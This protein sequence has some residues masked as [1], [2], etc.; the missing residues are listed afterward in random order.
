[1]VEILLPST[2]KIGGFDYEIKVDGET[3]TLLIDN[4]NWGEHSGRQRLL[5]IKSTAPP[6]QFSKT[7][8]HEILHAIDLVYQNGKLSNEEVSAISNGL[9]Q[10]LEQLDVRFVKEG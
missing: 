8:I 5:R 9:L 1:M 4:D 3:D 7:F 10:V 2:I 6:Q